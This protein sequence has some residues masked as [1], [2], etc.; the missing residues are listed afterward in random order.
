LSVC[1]VLSACESIRPTRPASMRPE[2][3]V[4]RYTASVEATRMIDEP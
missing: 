2:P 1:V 3:L 4:M